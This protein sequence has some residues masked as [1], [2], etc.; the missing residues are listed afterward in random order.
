MRGCVPERLA[1]PHAQ[2]DRLD[3]HA[4]TLRKARSKCGHQALDRSSLVLG[5]RRA[6]VTFCESGKT[7]SA[8]TFP[9]FTQIGPSG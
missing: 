4:D 3:F 2:G 1:K 5:A 7:R 9:G 8:M 6:D